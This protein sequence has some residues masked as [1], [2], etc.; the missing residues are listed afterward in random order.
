MAAPA[1]R[2][3]MEDIEPTNSKGP[4]SLQDP[5]PKIPT[6]PDSKRAKKF[7][8]WRRT[9]VFWLTSSAI[10]FAA[11]LS[12]TLWAYLRAPNDDFT[13]YYNRNLYEGRCSVAKSI[14]TGVHLLLNV[15]STL[16]LSGGYYCMQC[17]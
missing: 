10:V 2:P 1:A 6:A 8:K 16:L 9:L 4:S 13:S 12:F 3:L 14:N 7:P 11:Q 17:E 5:E 15:L